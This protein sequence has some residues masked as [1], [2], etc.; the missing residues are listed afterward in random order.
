MHNKFL[1]FCDIINEELDSYSLYEVRPHTVWTG[2][3]NLT[4]NATNSLENA[5]V[6]T[7]PGI[8]RAYFREWGQV[9]ALSE[10]L[11]WQTEWCEPEWRIGS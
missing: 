3:F 11:D 4:K 1:A 6:L 7:N 10:T 9:L 5:L 8:V 2:S